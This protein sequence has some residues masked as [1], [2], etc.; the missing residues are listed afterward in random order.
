[1]YIAFFLLQYILAIILLQMEVKNNLL[2]FKYQ[3]DMLHNFQFYF[4][5]LLNGYIIFGQ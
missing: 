3:S 2:Y 5:L 1:M 4:R